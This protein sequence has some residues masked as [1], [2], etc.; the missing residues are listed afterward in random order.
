M[1]LFPETTN[2][3]FEMIEN[4]EKVL[5]GKS[6]PRNRRH[7]PPPPVDQASSRSQVEL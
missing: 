4:R 3:Y 7:Q 5:N 1:F 2:D 6:S